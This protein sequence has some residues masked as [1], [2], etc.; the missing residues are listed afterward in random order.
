MP[1]RGV[2]AL[3]AAQ[4][5]LPD[6]EGEVEERGEGVG[7]LDDADGGDDGDEAGEGGDC[8]ADDEGDGPV[9]GDEGD[10]EEFAVSVGERWGVEEFNGDVVVEDCGEGALVRSVK[11][12]G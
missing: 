10:P 1:G 6:A 9:N 2:E 4:G 5:V 7:E 12:N 8:G 3:A 11:S